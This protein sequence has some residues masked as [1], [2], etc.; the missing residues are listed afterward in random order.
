MLKTIYFVF[1]IK[2]NVEKLFDDNQQKDEFR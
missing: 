2:E 1:L